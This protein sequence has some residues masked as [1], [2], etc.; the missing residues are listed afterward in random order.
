MDGDEGIVYRPSLV[1]LCKSVSKE[2]I[3]EAIKS[4]CDTVE[5]I[6][7]RTHASTGCGT[8]RNQVARILAEY[9]ALQNSGGSI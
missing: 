1:C 7:A 9:Q 6:S 8:C 2:E 4:G 3:I 5:K